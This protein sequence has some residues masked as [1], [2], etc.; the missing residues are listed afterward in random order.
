MDCLPGKQVLIPPIPAIDER[1]LE[2]PLE[3]SRFTWR[4]DHTNQ[5]PLRRIGILRLET[6]ESD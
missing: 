3:I 4:A 2:H 5:L 1:Y 6:K